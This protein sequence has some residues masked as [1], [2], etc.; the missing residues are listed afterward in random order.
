VAVEPETISVAP[1]T[2][3]HLPARRCKTH[4]NLLLDHDSAGHA[5][6]EP[7]CLECV[8]AHR[9]GCPQLDAM[10]K[11]EVLWDH[12]VIGRYYQGSRDLS[13]TVF[14]KHFGKHV[15]S[16]SCAHRH[17]AH[18]GHTDL[19]LT[20]TQPL[21]LLHYGDVTAPIVGSLR[22]RIAMMLATETGKFDW[23]Y[24]DLGSMDGKTPGMEAAAGKN[25][26]EVMRRLRAFEEHAEKNLRHRHA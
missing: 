9:D 3:V 12:A 10:R 4:G 24:Q 7:T 23:H 5:F 11:A 18:N 16:C 2:I 6:G 21:F 25:V 1:A 15:P 19:P 17:I 13:P 22:H 8:P 14:R 20:E 26:R